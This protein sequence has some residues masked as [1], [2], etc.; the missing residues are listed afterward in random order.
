MVWN[1]SGAL[2]SKL[3]L[4]RRCL[5]WEGDFGKLLIAPSKILNK[6]SCGRLPFTS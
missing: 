6:V 5:Q 4:G 3:E 1:S 2:G